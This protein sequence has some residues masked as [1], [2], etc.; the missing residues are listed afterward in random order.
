MHLVGLL[1]SICL[2]GRRKV[3]DNRQHRSALIVWPRGILYNFPVE[4]NLISVSENW[5]INIGSTLN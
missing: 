5:Y 4:E 2:R 3:V 1:H